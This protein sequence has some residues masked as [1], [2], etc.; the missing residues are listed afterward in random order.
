MAKKVLGTGKGSGHGRSLWGQTGVQ[1]AQL[2]FADE[3]EKLAALEDAA[4]DYFTG[5]NEIDK[6]LKE[7]Q[8]DMKAAAKEMD[9]EKAAELRDRVH[10]VKRIQ[11]EL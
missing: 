9:F 5:L 6:A 8:K 3:S 10:L 2:D 7:M 1:E 4:G 11:L